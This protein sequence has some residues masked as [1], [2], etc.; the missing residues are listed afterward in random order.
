MTPPVPLASPESDAATSG[1]PPLAETAPS[2]SHGL[3]RGAD[4]A[5]RA[6]IEREL[7]TRL[8]EFAVET[9]FAHLADTPVDP[10][11]LAVD[12]ILGMESTAG[13]LASGLEGSL[14]EGVPPAAPRRDGDRLA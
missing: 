14:L 1:I 10:A 9:V 13:R 2:P 12:L 8:Q 4:D 11:P 5:H 3:T 7:L 6:E